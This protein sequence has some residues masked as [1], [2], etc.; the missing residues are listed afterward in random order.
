MFSDLVIEG[1]ARDDAGLARDQG[2]AFGL[3]LTEAFV[4]VRALLVV[5][6][7]FGSVL[8][9]IEPYDGWLFGFATG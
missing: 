8:D 4:F 5:L 7:G 3:G 2:L 1:M 9:R 6:E